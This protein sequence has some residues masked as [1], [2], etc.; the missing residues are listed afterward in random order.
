[1]EALG[2]PY[3]AFSESPD[4]W[5]SDFCIPF[6]VREFIRFFAR[7]AFWLSAAVAV[8]ACVCTARP[9]VAISGVPVAVAAPWAVT[10]GCDPH[11]E[12]V[13]VALVLDP[14]EARILPEIMA[15]VPSI[16]GLVIC[17][18]SSLVHDCCLS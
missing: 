3:I 17:M 15:S 14:H 4:V 6:C 5:T 2:P 12:P 9:I 16:T 1:M 13:D 18:S 8:L 7:L 10:V 11:A